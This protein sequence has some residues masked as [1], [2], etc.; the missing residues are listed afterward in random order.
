MGLPNFKRFMEQLPDG[1]HCSVRDAHGNTH[2]GILPSLT[3]ERGA[4]DYGFPE[5]G[6][7]DVFIK[8]P[9]EVPAA[10]LQVTFM[11]KTYTRRILRTRDYQGKDGKG[12]CQV[13]IG[14][15]A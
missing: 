14:G 10:R 2:D 15:A 1:L 12:I 5:F 7:E 9:F 6:E 8:H 11:G 3:S 4:T 13:T